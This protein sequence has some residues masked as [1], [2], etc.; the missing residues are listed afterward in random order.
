MSAGQ[1]VLTMVDIR[2]HALVVPWAEEHQVEQDLLLSV[3]MVALFNDDFLS[4]EIAMR[5]GT[6]LHKVHLAPAARYSEDIDLV[7]VGARPEQHIRAALKRVL[8][9]ILGKHA[10]DVIASVK[11]TVRNVL[12][13]SRIIRLEYR[14]PSV[15]MPG[16]KLKVKF[17]VNTTERKPYVPV[18]KMPFSVGLQGRVRHADVASY[19][20]NEMLGTKMRALFQRK[21]GRDLFDLYWALTGPAAIPPDPRKVVA[22]FQHYMRAEGSRI[23]RQDFYEAL[24][25]RIADPDFRHDVPALLRQ[26]ISYDVDVAGAL[27]REQ[28]L[29]RL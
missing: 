3:A 9:P 17:E 2:Q 28:L 11:L 29:A 21:Q 14:W 27:V 26:G 24:D 4:R 6:V 1:F 20:V 12:K 15:T 22:A 8:L 5:G 7:A 10:T 23:S 25:E 16:Q 19:D 13:P 18:V